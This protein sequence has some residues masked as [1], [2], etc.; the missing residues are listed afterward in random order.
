VEHRVHEK[1]QARWCRL[2]TSAR[3]AFVLSWSFKSVC[4]VCV[5]SA[6]PPP[7][8]FQETTVTVP[9]RHR[10][11]CRTIQLPEIIAVLTTCAPSRSIVRAGRIGFATRASTGCQRTGSRV[12]NRAPGAVSMRDGKNCTPP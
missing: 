5:T 8:S 12:T 7:K 6:T 1:A 2:C 3:F 4:A 11:R 9:R 10:H